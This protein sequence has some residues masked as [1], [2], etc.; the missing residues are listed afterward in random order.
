MEGKPKTETEA[1]EPRQIVV[2]VDVMRKAN[3]FHDTCRMPECARSWNVGCMLHDARETMRMRQKAMS[4]SVV[5]VSR[6]HDIDSAAALT[7][8]CKTPPA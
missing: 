5:G 4:G 2:D 1:E 3:V 7:V 6:K 8:R